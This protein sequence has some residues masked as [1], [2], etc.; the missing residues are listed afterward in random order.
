MND[1][2]V[3]IRLPDRVYYGIEKGITVNGSAASQIVLEAVRNGILLPKGHGRLGDLDELEKEMDNDIKAGLF[4]DGYENYPHI[5]NMDDCVDCVR[6]TDTIIQA[7][8]EQE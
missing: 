6:Y 8:K 3:L 5:N 2:E 1:T 4:L 7:D